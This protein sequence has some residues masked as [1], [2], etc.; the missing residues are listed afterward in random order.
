M[1]GENGE[2]IFAHSIAQIFPKMCKLVT[3]RS[4]LGPHLYNTVSVLTWQRVSQT[5]LKVRITT[6]DAVSDECFHENM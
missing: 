3:E 6:S 1:R 4:D 5:F 2:A